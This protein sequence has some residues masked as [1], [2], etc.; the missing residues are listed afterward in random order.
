MFRCEPNLIPVPEPP[1][2]LYYIVICLKYKYK[3]DINSVHASCFG[4]T[5]T[6]VWL[7]FEWIIINEYY[8][9]ILDGYSNID[10]QKT[11]PSADAARAAGITIFA[12]GVGPE[13]DLDPK[14]LMGL[15]NDP[16]YQ[17]GFIMRNSSMIDSTA[18]SVLDTIC[19]S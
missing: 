16:D 5:M 9:N 3:H 17:Y 2:L 18:N 11:L 12:I 13:G 15:A 14:E 19:A 6:K 10:R 1:W 8:Y 7:P 4:M